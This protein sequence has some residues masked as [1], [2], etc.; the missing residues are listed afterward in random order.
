MEVLAS[1]LPSTSVKCGAHVSPMLGPLFPQP[2]AWLACSSAS[3]NKIFNFFVKVFLD[4]ALTSMVVRLV[5][6][7]MH[8]AAPMLAAFAEY[9]P[10]FRFSI[11][12]CCL[13]H[14]LQSWSK[15]PAPRRP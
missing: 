6:C 3:K 13:G 1:Q 11:Q 15:L 14:V 9:I 10:T 7:L 4:M 2:D 8:P 5:P 12:C